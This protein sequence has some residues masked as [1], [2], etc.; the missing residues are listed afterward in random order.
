MTLTFYIWSFVL[1]AIIC[2]KSIVIKKKSN[3]GWCP[4]RC[5]IKSISDLSMIVCG[6]IGVIIAE[7]WMKTNESGR[8]WFGPLF[9]PIG[10]M[11]K[12]VI[13]LYM[14]IIDGGRNIDWGKLFFFNDNRTRW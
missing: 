14:T 9:F 13:E 4:V 1:M 3:S 6:E 12:F 5:T 7:Q 10:L 11:V 8:G 2:A